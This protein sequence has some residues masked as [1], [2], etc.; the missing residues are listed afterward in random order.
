MCI[1]AV[2]NATIK[3]GQTC[4]R[5]RQRKTLSSKVGKTSPWCTINKLIFTI[6][7][8]CIA[9]TAWKPTAHQLARSYQTQ[10]V[11]ITPTTSMEHDLCPKCTNGCAMECGAAFACTRTCNTKLASAPGVQLATHP[12][13]EHDVPIS[14]LTCHSVLAA[15]DRCPNMLQHAFYCVA[16]LQH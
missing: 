9:S 12:T 11:K 5:C 3:H 15:V 7:I 6:K 4:F 13:P 1:R 14:V 10:P 2:D 8:L 16:G